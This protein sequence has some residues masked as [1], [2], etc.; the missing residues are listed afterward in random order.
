M[1]LPTY[2][3]ARI[4]NWREPRFAG[5]DTPNPFLGFI[6]LPFVTAAFWIGASIVIGGA[7]GAITL[8]SVR[9]R[10]KTV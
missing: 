4:L 7:I 9:S 10:M 2:W 6:A 5:L 3:L 1:I 8:A